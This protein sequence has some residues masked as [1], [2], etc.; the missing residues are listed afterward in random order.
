MDRAGH[1][2]ALLCRAD[3]L[4]ALY[5]RSG[6]RWRFPLV[7]LFANL[8]LARVLR[9][10]PELRR[11]PPAAR[12]LAAVLET[13]TA[14]H[15]AL[16]RAWQVPGSAPALD[17]VLHAVRS[18]EPL[19]PH[20]HRALFVASLRWEQREIVEPA[21]AP[22]LVGLP[23][24]MRVAMCWMPMRL[25]SGWVLYRDFLDARARI[26]ATVQSYDRI[27]EIGWDTIEDRAALALR[28][29]RGRV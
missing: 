23:G 8:W 27:G 12:V 21:F 28:S 20:A 15:D 5:R 16:W 14:V 11:I 7:S 17:S 2:D 22:V 26:S 18:G 24:W 19:S 29:L 3:S 6:R 9:W 13:N 25:A 10:C 4:L 1:I